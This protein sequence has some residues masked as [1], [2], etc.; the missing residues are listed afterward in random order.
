MLYGTGK[1]V[2]VVSVYFQISV[3]STRSCRVN[4]NVGG[5]SSLLAPFSN[6]NPWLCA[7]TWAEGLF[8]QQFLVYS[9]NG[10]FKMALPW[11]FGHSLSSVIFPEHKIIIVGLDNAGKTTILYQL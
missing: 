6:V 4:A 1:F 2:V 5:F 9:I 7:C 10:V 11:E 8:V 3:L